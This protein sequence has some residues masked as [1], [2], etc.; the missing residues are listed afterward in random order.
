MAKLVH[1]IQKKQHRERSQLQS[2]SKYGLL[3]K[4]KDY[5]KRA[6]NYHEKEQSIKY[7]KNKIKDK[8]NDEFY[9]GMNT[10]QSNTSKID[11][12]LIKDLSIDEIKLLKTQDLNYINNIKN[13]N[14][15]SIEKLIINNNLL[16][17]NNNNN[18]HTIFVDSK[19]KLINFNPK[20]FFNTTDDLLY[21]NFNRLTKDQLQ[22]T[23]LNNNTNIN[24]DK[25]KLK[26]LNN[27]KLKINNNN[28]LINISNKLQLQ[29]KLINDN[30][31]KKKLK[32][33]NGNVTFKWSKKRKS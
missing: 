9:Y 3:E 14:K 4:H 22:D 25:K 1:N 11:S 15:K 31:N 30:G 2:R 33:S 16:L 5:V 10:E 12:N 24:I 13:L 6:K 27:L 17:N 26:K 20:V 29:K 23:K 18:K 8:N 21:R 7:L 28:K 19:D 32:D